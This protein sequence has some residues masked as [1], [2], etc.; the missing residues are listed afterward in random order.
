MLPLG[1]SEKLEVIDVLDLESLTQ[2]WTLDVFFDPDLVLLWCGSS[3]NVKT[4]PNLTKCCR[5]PDSSMI[6]I[7]ML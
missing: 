2:I 6:S 3:N 1:S 4:V 7:Q 5:L